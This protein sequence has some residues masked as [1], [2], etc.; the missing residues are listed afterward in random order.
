[1]KDNGEDVDEKETEEINGEDSQEDVENKDEENATKEDLPPDGSNEEKV[2]LW[3]MD[4][5]NK[6][7]HFSKLF[8]SVQSGRRTKCRRTNGN[9]G[10]DP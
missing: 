5:W 4:I 10:G 6:T 3:S 7:Q 2:S 9:R 1:M 8:Y